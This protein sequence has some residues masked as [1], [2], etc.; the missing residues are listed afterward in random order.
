MVSTKPHLETEFVYQLEVAHLQQ[1]MEICNLAVQFI[2]RE[3]PTLYKAGL[4]V[5]HMK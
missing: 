5:E 3:L 4:K 1:D 2:G